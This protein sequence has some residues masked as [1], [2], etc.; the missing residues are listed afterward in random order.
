MA[1]RRRCL[2]FVDGWLVFGLADVVGSTGG[3][4]WDGVGSRR[5]SSR[6]GAAKRIISGVFSLNSSGATRVKTIQYCKVNCANLL[7][8]RR[9]LP[10]TQIAPTARKVAVRPKT[11]VSMSLLATKVRSAGWKF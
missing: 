7:V 1:S 6:S 8:G 5:P 3:F 10:V 2:S 4:V 9:C 11:R